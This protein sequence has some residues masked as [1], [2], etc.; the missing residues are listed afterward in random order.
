MPSG[1]FP[2][3]ASKIHFEV[4]NEGEWVMHKGMLTNSLSVIA[5]GLANVFINEQQGVVIAELG[6]GDIF[7][8]HSAM[9]G[10]KANAS[11]R[12]KVALELISIHRDDLLKLLEQFPEFSQRLHQIER[13]RA[14]ENAFIVKWT[15]AKGGADNAKQ[16]VAAA[17]KAEA[18]ARCSR[19]SKG[20]GSGSSP[21][22]C[23][24]SCRC[25]ANARSM[26]KRMSVA[27][28]AFTQLSSK[29]NNQGHHAPAPIRKGSAHDN[30]QHRK[31]VLLL[32]NHHPCH[33]A[34]SV[35]VGRGS[36]KWQRTS[37]TL[38]VRNK[39]TSRTSGLPHWKVTLVRRPAWAGA[40]LTASRP[41]N[42]VDPPSRCPNGIR[43]CLSMKSL[44]SR[45]VG[46]ALAY[47]RCQL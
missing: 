46:A 26:A 27:S 37:L 12:A 29:Q 14:R 32:R 24:S 30:I 43:E 16:S 44:L 17:A 20:E 3:F 1:F 8:E 33:R 34:P 21:K 13:R 11:I 35:W 7:G 40:S 2:T 45:G 10:G 22:P 19:A 47:L 31:I 18:D 41:N 38:V 28:P 25:L 9:T 4:Y 5:K 15:T 39:T 23:R 42:N 36:R 6:G